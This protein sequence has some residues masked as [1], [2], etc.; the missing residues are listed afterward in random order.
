MIMKENAL[1]LVVY[2][3]FKFIDL[4]IKISQDCQ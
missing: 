1:Q 3:Y 2:S 4:E